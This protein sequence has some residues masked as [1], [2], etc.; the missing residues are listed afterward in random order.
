MRKTMRK[1]YGLGEFADYG[2]W[3]LVDLA[4]GTANERKEALRDEFRDFL[5]RHGMRGS[6]GGIP[7]LKA[8]VFMNWKR[9]VVTR[10]MLHFVREWLD[11]VEEVERYEF[12]DP[13]DARRGSWPAEWPCGNWDDLVEVVAQGAAWQTFKWHRK[14]PG[15]SFL[16]RLAEEGVDPFAEQV[17]ESSGTNLIRRK[18]RQ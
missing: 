8:L 7:Y 1:K 10:W 16:D 14:H 6:F 9:S 18:K 13:V 4:E 2:F 15:R 3:V 12:S 17:R 11:Q 5:E